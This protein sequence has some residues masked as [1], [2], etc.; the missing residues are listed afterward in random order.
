MSAS[1]M[2]PCRV[3]EERDAVIERLSIDRNLRQPCGEKIEGINENRS[4]DAV[5]VSKMMLGRPPTHPGPSADLRCGRS[6]KSHIRDGFD[7]GTLDPRLGLGCPFG[8]T[9]PGSQWLRDLQSLSD[10]HYA[11]LLTDV[12]P[13]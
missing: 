5:L 11:A 7:D 10:V 1:E 13:A 4:Q 2:L 6:L 3:D 9:T 8:V 12:S